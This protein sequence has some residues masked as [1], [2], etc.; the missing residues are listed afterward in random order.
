MPHIVLDDQQAQIVSE[1]TGYVE[2]R[3]RRGRHLGF[4][5]HDFTDAEIQEAKRRAASNEPRYTTAQVL[6]HLESLESQ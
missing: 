4:V 2:I 1:I 3:D 6:Q 5:A